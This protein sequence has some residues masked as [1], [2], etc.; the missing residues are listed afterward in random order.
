MLS[1]ADAQVNFEYI[2]FSQ[3]IYHTFHIVC[4]S[5]SL[6]K[7]KALYIL[8][9]ELIHQ[10]GD[11]SIDISIGNVSNLVQSMNFWNNYHQI[12][13]KNYRLTH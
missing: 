13:S 12:C 2:F 4:L 10:Q 9:S 6:R 11:Q 5:I 3:C 7:I 1:W 8:S